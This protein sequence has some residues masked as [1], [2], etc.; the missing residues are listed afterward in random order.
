MQDGIGPLYIASQYGY[1]EVV[2]ALLESGADP[3]LACMVWVLVWLF[4]V[5]CV[6]M[7]FVR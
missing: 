5:Y 2:N 7:H 6:L 4:H 1:T 3:S